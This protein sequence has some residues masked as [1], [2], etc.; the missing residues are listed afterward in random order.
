MHQRPIGVA[1]G[2]CGA[3]GRKHVRGAIRSAAPFRTSRSTL[4]RQ[5]LPPN[6]S[7]DGSGKRS[8]DPGSLRMGTNGSPPGG[9]GDPND[10]RADRLRR[11]GAASLHPVPSTCDSGGRTRG[12]GV[13]GHQEVTDRCGGNHPLAG[14]VPNVNSRYN[15]SSSI[16]EPVNFIGFVRSGPAFGLLCSL[17]WGSR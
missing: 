5:A 4:R 16:M 12:A 2:N 11:L 17:L 13:S 15:S 7:W 9:G 8:A 10:G 1:L 3:G 6:R 14:G